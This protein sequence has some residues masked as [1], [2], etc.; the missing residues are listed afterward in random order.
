MLYPDPD[1]DAEPTRG[2][3]LAKRGINVAQRFIVDREGNT[4]DGFRAQAIRD[5]TAFFFQQLLMMGQAPPKWGLECPLN[6]R[7]L[8]YAEICQHFPELRLCESNWKAELVAL[9]CYSGWYNNHV[10]KPAAKR[11]REEDTHENALVNLDGLETIDDVTGVELAG[12]PQPSGKG[13]GRAVVGREPKK[14]K[15]APLQITNPL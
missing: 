6:I 15:K 14:A 12:E 2:K 5:H 3:A 9:R 1:I 4:I 7:K 8:Y 13:K 11:A 10:K